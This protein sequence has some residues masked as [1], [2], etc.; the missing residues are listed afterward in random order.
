MQVFAFTRFHLRLVIA[1]L[2]AMAGANLSAQ[3][4]ST[5]QGNISDP[6]GGSVPGAT[7]TATNEETGGSRSATTAEDGYYRIPDLLAGTYR[8]SVE[9]AGF[10]TA[11]RTGVELTAKTVFGQN[12]TL[13]LGAVTESVTVTAEGNQVETQEVRINDVIRTNDLQS[14]PMLGRTPVSLVLTSP[15]ITGK[16]ESLGG[17]YCCDEFAALEAPELSSGGNEI[18]MSYTVDGLSLRYGDGATWGMSFSP[19]PDALQEVNVAASAYTAEQGG[20]SGPQVQLITKG[21]TNALHGTGHYTFRNNDLNAVPFGSTRAQVPNAYYRLFGGTV[22]GPIIKN[23]LFWFFAYEGK[24]AQTAGS[25]VVLAETED[26]KNWVLAT[27]PNSIAAQL[28]KNYPPIRYPKDNLADL[29][30]LG[31]PDIGTVVVNSPGR[32]EGKQFNGR[33]DYQPGG[34][35]RIYGSYWY[36][37]PVDL[38]S[39]LRPGFA[40]TLGITVNYGNFAYSHAFSP[41][42]LNE[43]RLG[44]SDGSVVSSH[45][46]KTY[47]VPAIS[48]DDGL[49]MGNFAWALDVWQT[50]VAEFGDTLS[51]NRGKHGI[52]VGGGYSVRHLALQSLIGYDTPE[53]DFGSILDFADDKPYAEHR[54]LDVLSGKANKTDETQGDNQLYFFA[55]NTWQVHPNLTLNYGLRWEDFYPPFLTMKGKQTWE[56]VLLSSQ[57]TPTNVASVINR[58]VHGYAKNDWNNFGPRISVAWDPRGN[59]RLSIRGSFSMLYDELNALHHYNTGANPPGT[60][61]VVAGPQYSVPIVYGLAPV[62]TR[63][64][65]QNPNL[66]APNLTPQ[67]GFVGVRPDIAGFVDNLQAPLVYDTFVGVQYQLRRDVMV[68]GDYRY[69]RC[70]NDVYADD[71]NRFQGDL[72]VNHGQLARLNPDFSSINI[73]T[74]WGKRIYNGLVFGASKR[75]SHGWSLDAH[76]TYNHQMS[77][78]NLIATHYPTSGST[79]SY[80]PNADWGRDDIPHV[81]TLRGVWDLPIFRNGSDWLGRIAGGWQL[82]SM[83]NLQSGGIFNP[84]SR[85]RYGQ[86]GDFNAD[87]R[88]ADRPDLPNGNVP[89]SFPSWQW[90]QGAMTGSIFPLPDPSQPRIGTLP[91]SYF[92]GPGYARI[93]IGADKSFRPWER[94]RIQFRADA[95]NALNR[96][97]IARVQSNI[98]ASNFAH[99]TSFYLKRVIQLE[100]RAEF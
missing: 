44:I 68:F 19:N 66:R 86:G 75:F 15:G 84:I 94:L 100:V 6:N 34:K 95:F 12:F 73:L 30:G 76:Y 54:T 90:V 61:D 50:K 89:R 7:V 59:G 63:D 60:A 93:D 9:R 45:N 58:Q 31:F 99:A 38:G 24:K 85:K 81:F 48:T 80:N 22:G 52:K 91:K 11:I 36:T 18:K 5:I 21:G 69:R 47:N 64:F 29:L 97:N 8:L 83:W 53:Y 96:T 13:Q 27:R 51:V 74:N 4:T 49:S 67:G 46:G 92:R 43:A 26:F 55:Q 70:T 42:V 79:A 88:N 56:P 20:L 41:N 77:N 35:D 78:F 10:K 2:V 33:I 62:G 98:F 3:V 32:Q 72:L 1:A 23:R 65:P 28:L 87:G 16:F 82:S 40:L 71:L 39:D 57:L 17:A 14:L 25:S 37:R